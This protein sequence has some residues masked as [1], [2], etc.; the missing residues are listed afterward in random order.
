[1]AAA[2]LIPSFSPQLC[3]DCRSPFVHCN[4]ALMNTRLLEK[5]IEAAH[6]LLNYLT[7]LRSLYLEHDDILYQLMSFD[8]LVS[9]NELLAAACRFIDAGMAQELVNPTPPTH[10]FSIEKDV[11]A[12]LKM[13]IINLKLRLDSLEKVQQQDKQKLFE[14][15]LCQDE[16]STCILSLQ[17]EV[18]GP[19]PPAWVPEG[20]TDASE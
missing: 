10:D 1:M 13:E 6:R 17:K 2:R 18:F 15:Q 3:D 9:R 4:C 12:T 11:A 8:P 14:S 16:L 20:E 19:S 5:D 7:H